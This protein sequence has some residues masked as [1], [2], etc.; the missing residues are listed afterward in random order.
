MPREVAFNSKYRPLFADPQPG[1]PR[2]TVIT[3]GRGSGKSYA[4]SSANLADTYRNDRSILYSRYTLVSADISI[5]PE[6]VDKMTL[7]GRGAHFRTTKDTITNLQSG[8]TMY[9]R[10]ILGSSG[11]Q[12]ARLKSIAKL[13]KFVLDEAQELTRES[14]FDTIDLS[15]REPDVHNDVQLILNPSDIHHWIYRRFF[16]AKGVPYDFNGVVDDVRFIHTDWRDNRAN[17]HPSFIARALE[18]ERTDPERYANIYLGDWSVKRNGLIYPRW[19]EVA[20]AD[21]PVGLDWWYGNDWGYGGDPDALVR[22]AFDPLTRTL[23]VVEVLYSTG[24]LPRDVAAAIRQD[25][26]AHGIDVGEVLVY[27]DPARPDSI[28]ELRTQY[29]INALPGINRDKPG[30]IGYLQGFKVRYVGRG[31]KSEVETYSWKPNKW[32]EDTFSDVPQDGNDHDMDA[33]SYSTTHLRRLGIAND[34]GDLPQ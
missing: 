10:G 16:K 11:N 19:Q 4:V 17:L 32:D 1:D 30:R 28:A 26:K 15:I 3:G 34:A 33:I 7:F 9:F 25:C 18:C 21:I 27:C 23:Y 5:I 13:R 14:D 20:E 24:K 31:I 22:V 8:G 2:Y 29:G 12:T 6:Y